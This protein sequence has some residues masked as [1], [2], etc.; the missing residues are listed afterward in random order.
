MHLF[1]S[2][3]VIIPIFS[4]LFTFGITVHSHVRQFSKYEKVI[5][6]PSNRNVT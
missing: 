1:I 2:L 5:K 4:F 6:V 3:T